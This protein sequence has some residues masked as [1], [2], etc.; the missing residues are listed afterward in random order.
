MAATIAEIREKLN[1][2]SDSNSKVPHVFSPYQNSHYCN[3]EP[4]SQ[5]K[6]K[7]SLEDIFIKLMRQYKSTHNRKYLQSFFPYYVFLD[8]IFDI[9]GKIV[10]KIHKERPPNTNYNTRYV[11]EVTRDFYDKYSNQLINFLPAIGGANMNVDYRPRVVI[12]DGI[13]D[14]FFLYNKEYTFKNIAQ[15]KEFKEILL[16]KINGKFIYKKE[17]HLQGLPF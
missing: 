6:T 12:H 3:F 14:I 15:R 16:N 11:L 4:F 5:K 1:R 10:L 13:D 2:Y 9:D 8:S 17:V 7:N